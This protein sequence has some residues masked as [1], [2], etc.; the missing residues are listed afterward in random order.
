MSAGA[1]GA[2]DAAWDEALR[3]GSVTSEQALALF[4][5]LGSI[6][7]EDMLGSWSGHEFPS[8]HPL[9]GALE[10]CHWFGKRFDSR[11]DVHPLVFCGFGARRWTVHPSR[12]F[13]ARSLVMRFPALKSPALGQLV[14]LLLPLLATRESR[15]RLRTIT[16]RG[17]ATAAMVY[18]DLPIIDVFR[19][20]NPDTVLGLMDCKGMAQP[21]FFVLR[22]EPEA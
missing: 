22:R 17:A 14:R 15:A 4:D 6:G 5:G 18:D 20:V 12:I 1:P 13:W 16:Y 3:A 11:E 19:S 7:R 10:A 8:G 2:Q 21:Y 9:D